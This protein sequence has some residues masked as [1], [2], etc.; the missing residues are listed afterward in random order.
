MPRMMQITAVMTRSIKRLERPNSKSERCVCAASAIRPV[1]RLTCPATEARFRE[2]IDEDQRDASGVQGSAAAKLH[3]IPE[4]ALVQ[5]ATTATLPVIRRMTLYQW[6][7]SA[8][9]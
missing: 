6:I 1:G 8:S 2:K 9:E 5:P 7:P 3:R 4:T